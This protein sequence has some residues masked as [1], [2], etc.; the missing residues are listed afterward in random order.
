MVDDLAWDHASPRECDWV[1]GCYLL[2]RREM[3]ERIGLFD[4]RYFLSTAKKWTCAAASNKK[5]GA[6]CSSTTHKWFT[7]VESAKADGPVTAGGQQISALR[8]ESDLLYFRKNHGLIGLTNFVLLTWL[9]DLVIAAKELIKG[10][11]SRAVKAIGQH[12][13]ALGSALQETHLKTKPTR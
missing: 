1:S 4:P 6:L 10:R 12:S 9:S 8:I 5:A 11:G 13:L 2:I 7:W 3:V